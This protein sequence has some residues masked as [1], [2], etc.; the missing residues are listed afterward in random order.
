LKKRWNEANVSVRGGLKHGSALGDGR[1]LRLPIGKE[2]AWEKIYLQGDNDRYKEP[3]CSSVF[4][5]NS[6]SIVFD[7]TK[8]AQNWH[9]GTWVNH[10]MLMEMAKFYPG[11]VYGTIFM[12]SSDC[13]LNL[14][15]RPCLILALE[16]VSKKTKSVPQIREVN[17]NW[18]NALAAAG[19]QGKLVLVN[20]LSGKSLTSRNFERV[21][22]NAE[23][24]RFISTNF[25]EVRLDGD[26]EANKQFLKN[27]GL[28]HFPTSFIVAPP[29]RAG[30]RTFSKI[31]P[32]DWNTLFGANRS[33][34][35]FSQMYAKELKNILDKY[36][37]TKNLD[38]TLDAKGQILRGSGFAGGCGG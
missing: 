14:R 22:A 19:R 28:S 23:V 32:Y 25:I 5:Q 36:S 7:I 27:Y 3:V 37:Q 31:E 11:N 17:R 13:P 10:G 8:A 1:S 9:K 4:K 34:F 35:E 2:E 29:N 18:K 15:K 21:L 38:F 6:N 24:K 16:N 26:K 12:T 20:V 33:N 30:L